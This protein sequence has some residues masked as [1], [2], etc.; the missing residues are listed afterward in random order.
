MTLTHTNTNN[1]ADSSGDVT[2]A[3]FQH[4]NGL[5]P[6]GKDIVREM[7]RLGVMVDISHVADKTFY[8]A[9]ETSQAPLIASHSA[10]RAVT[11]VPRNLTDEMIKALAQKGG[12]I[13]INFFCN[14]A[15][16]KPGVRAMLAG[17]GGAYRSR[18]RDCRR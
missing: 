7:N 13:Q 18:E 14:F 9:L 10:C 11:D 15:T 6:L 2:K 5:T 12:V 16:R 8:D 3:D 17:C 1:W 4:H